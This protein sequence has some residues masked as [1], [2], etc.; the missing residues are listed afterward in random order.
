M[1]YCPECCNDDV[2]GIKRGSKRFYICG[3]C[4]AEWVEIDKYDLPSEERPQHKEIKIRVLP[5]G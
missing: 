4:G 2:D 1:S 3:I 5:Y